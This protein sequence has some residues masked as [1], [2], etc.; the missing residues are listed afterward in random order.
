MWGAVE[1]ADE[2]SKFDTIVCVK[3]SKVIDMILFQPA[4]EIKPKIQ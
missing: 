2:I 3:T 1:A 4:V